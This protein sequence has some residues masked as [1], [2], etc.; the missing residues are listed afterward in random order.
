MELV[1]PYEE[2]ETS[3]YS[4]LYEETRKKSTII[5]LDLPPFRTVRNY[6]QSPLP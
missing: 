1:S 2:E 3:T 5:I 4:L 6:Q